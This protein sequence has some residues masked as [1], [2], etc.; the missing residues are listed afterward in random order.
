MLQVD[1]LNGRTVL[2]AGSSIGRLFPDVA[3]EHCSA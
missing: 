2:D 1:N 3:K